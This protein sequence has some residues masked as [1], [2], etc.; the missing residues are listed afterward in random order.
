MAT[1]RFIHTCFARLQASLLL[2]ATAFTSVGQ[3]VFAEPAAVRLTKFGFEQL[4][5][6]VMLVRATLDGR[7]DSLNFILD[8]GS[9]GISLDSVTVAELGLSLEPSNRTIRGIAG[10][11]QVSFANNHRLN[12]PGLT[13]D[14]LNFHVNDYGLLSAVYGF[15]IDGIIGYSFFKRYI[16][17]INYDNLTI[18]VFSPGAYRYP[19]GGHMLRPAISGLPMQYAEFAENHRF[20]GRFYLDTGAG[21]CLLLSQDYCTDSA[22]FA[23]HKKFYNTVA[24]GLGGKK[25]MKLTVIKQFKLGPY[26]FKKVPVFVFD[27]EFNVTAYPFLGGL[28]GNDLL[29]RFNLVVNYGRSQIHLLPNTHFKE[30]FD[31]SYTGL[32]LY[33]EGDDIVVGEIMPQSPAEK[34]GLQV[35]DI[36]KGVQNNL[37]NN[38]QQYKLLMQNTTQR[39]RVIYNRRG[40]FAQT[41]ISVKSIKKS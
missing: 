3:E 13:V 34:A 18:E 31:Y 30:E 36:I 24:E 28:I 10:V 1:A 40:V 2:L 7:T 26:R 15:K 35:G 22:I 32:S 9:G 12:L 8:T 25:F 23:P 4:S 14:S 29:R 37:T 39:I 33:M 19:R 5:G 21:L 27:D 20:L 38:L 17:R 6:G 11:R 41:H 16:V